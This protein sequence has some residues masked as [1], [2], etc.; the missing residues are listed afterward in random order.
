[1]QKTVS[2]VAA[3]LACFGPPIRAPYGAAR[4]PR[5]E[6]EATLSSCF[7]TRDEHGRIQGLL[8]TGIKLPVFLIMDNLMVHHAK[9]LKEWFG[10]MQREHGFRIFYL[11]SHSPELNPDKYFNRD[12]WWNRESPVPPWNSAMP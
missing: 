4:H 1:M 2:Y 12:V 8:R 11:P 10:Q 9:N 7:S 3:P 6:T 5:S